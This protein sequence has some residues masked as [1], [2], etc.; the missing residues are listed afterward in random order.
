[1][2]MMVVVNNDGFSVL[3]SPSSKSRTLINHFRANLYHTI[4]ASSSRSFEQTSSKT[5]PVTQSTRANSFKNESMIATIN[6]I[7]TCQA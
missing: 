1:M 4:G 7:I 3:L 2:I 6:K 5:Q